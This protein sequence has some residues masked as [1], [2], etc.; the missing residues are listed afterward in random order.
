M[1]LFMGSRI[2]DLGDIGNDESSDIASMSEIPNAATYLYSQCKIF[3][4]YLRKFVCE[5]ER[6]GYWQ[7]QGI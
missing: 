5:F 3:L 7:A 1:R 2:H 4:P 6:S